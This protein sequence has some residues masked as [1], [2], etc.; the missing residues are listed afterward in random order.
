MT[1]VTDTSTRVVH[2]NGARADTAVM[3][4]SDGLSVCVTNIV[5]VIFVSMSRVIYS[6]IDAL[7]YNNT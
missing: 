7:L 2:D 6:F 5:D 4:L 1:V 3:T